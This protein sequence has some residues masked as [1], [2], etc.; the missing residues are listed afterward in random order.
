[1]VIIIF[2]RLEIVFSS[3][4]GTFKRIFFAVASIKIGFIISNSLDESIDDSLVFIDFLGV[5]LNFVFKVELV[6]SSCRA[7]SDFVFL[8]LNDLLVDGIFKAIEQSKE[9]SLNLRPSL[10][11]TIFEFG[12]FKFTLVV[13]NVTSA[14]FF[15]S[16]SL[17]RV[18]NI[19]FVI[20]S[21]LLFKFN[22]LSKVTSAVNS[23]EGSKLFHESLVL[24]EIE[25][26]LSFNL[27]AEEINEL[28]GELVVL[29]GFNE[30][31]ILFAT[32]GED[33][34]DSVNVFFD[35]IIQPVEVFKGVFE[36]LLVTFE[37]IR[38]ASAFLLFVL[39]LD[40]NGINI[41]LKDGFIDGPVIIK[42][43]LVLL[44]IIEQ[45]DKNVSGLVDNIFIV[46]K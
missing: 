13:V 38:N 12:E 25:G 22:E 6:F 40:S 44:G 35:T 17:D 4:E 18:V 21:D 39:Q 9:L 42:I 34:S 41:S 14:N 23:Q 36:F 46:G 1:M 29:E 20:G 31:A 45:L 2:S 43:L 5:D 10:S 3:S 30:I 33:L 24:S 15:I 8:S 32:L 7:G 28:Q 11:F 26:F 37:D 16:S 27:S 19:D